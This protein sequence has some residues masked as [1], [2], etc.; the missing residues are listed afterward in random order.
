M[1]WIVQ[2]YQDVLA[3]IGAI[4][5]VASMIVAMTPS[6][7]DDK[8]VGKAVKLIEKLSIFTKRTKK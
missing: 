6:T 5:S 3:V 7:D 4:V 2:N 8:L 1:E